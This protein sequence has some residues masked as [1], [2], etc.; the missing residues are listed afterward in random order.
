VPNAE[1]V[2][3]IRENSTPLSPVL[4]PELVL[5]TAHESL[6]LWTR[7]QEWIAAGEIPLPFWAFPWAGGQ[8]LARYVLDFPQS[9]QGK[10]VLDFGSG[11]GLVAIAASKAGA[12]RVLACDIDPFARA[13]IAL[14]AGLNEVPLEI[15]AFDV[16]KE[17]PADV[18][19][20]L[21][22]DVFYEREPALL[23]IAWFRQLRQ[24][25][26]QVYVGDPGR[27]YVPKEELEVLGTYVVPTSRELEDLDFRSTTVFRMK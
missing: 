18:D 22:G 9:V 4:L 10:T 3:F 1:Y 14:N 8:A 19:V 20:V 26:M 21:A 11:S 13:A 2:K 17:L 27:H 15:P 24:Q 7:A 23:F 12:A 16:M 5:W 25:E 6:P